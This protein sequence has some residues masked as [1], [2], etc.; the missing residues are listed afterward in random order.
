M[1][2]PT[3]PES[4]SSKMLIGHWLI[5][6]KVPHYPTTKSNNKNSG[7]FYLGTIH[8]PNVNKQKW[9]KEVLKKVHKQPVNNWNRGYLMMG[10]RNC[11]NNNR[12]YQ[13]KANFWQPNQECVNDL[14]QKS[15]NNVKNRD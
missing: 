3:N 14:A 10:R 7:Q 15:G 11:D 9:G 2:W 13:S 8:A 5:F 12:N 6:S 1:S 4:S